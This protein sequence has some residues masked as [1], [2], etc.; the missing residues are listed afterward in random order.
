MVQ[1]VSDSWH[2]I[3]GSAGISAVQAY[4]ESEGDLA[5][6]DE[7]HVDFAKHLLKR[8]GFLYRDS[9]SDNQKVRLVC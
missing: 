7:E 4:C 1:H 5:N 6:S 8:F 3:I 9:Y 2:N